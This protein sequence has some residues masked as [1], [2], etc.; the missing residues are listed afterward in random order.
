M[1]DRRIAGS[2]VLGT[3]Q[4]AGLGDSQGSVLGDSL[5]T[6]FPIPPR[7]EPSGLPSTAKGAA[8]PHM[9]YPH[10]SDSGVTA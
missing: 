2:A 3:S 8:P 6:G 10:K 7:G 1:E 5:G 9:T 4:S